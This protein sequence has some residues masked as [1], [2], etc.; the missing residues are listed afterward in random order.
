M[1]LKKFITTTLPYANSKP[2]IGHAFEFVL[3][4]VLTRYFRNTGK[5]VHFNTG[6][7]EHGT[8]IAEAAKNE[9]LTPKQFLDK[10]K[11]SWLTFCQKF[12]ISYD[13]FYRTSSEE[14]HEKVAA[15]WEEFRNRGDFYA[16]QYTGTYC[17]GC[18][19]F[20]TAR[21]LV[22]G[23][24]PDHPADYVS[25]SSETNIFFELTKYSKHLPEHLSKIHKLPEN[26][27]NELSRLVEESAD[28]SVSRPISKC[29]WG[30]PVPKSSLTDGIDDQV[31]Y[32]WFDALLNYIIAS[33]DIGWEDVTIL[34]GPDNLRFQSLIFQSMLIAMDK[35]A[36]KTTLFM[37]GTILD[38]NGHKMSKSK[39]NT[40]DPMDQLKKYGIDAVRY[41]MVA[42]LNPHEDSSWKE[43]DLVNMFNA[44]ICNNFGNL[45]SR[46]I[47]LYETKCEKEHGLADS[48]FLN[49]LLDLN[50]E[51]SL[52]YEEYRV[53]DA[54]NYAREISTKINQYI[55]EKEPWKQEK[56]D[57]QVTIG[58]ALAGLHMLLRLY[59]PVFPDACE[60]L[61]EAIKIHKTKIIAFQ[62]IKLQKTTT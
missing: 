18:E 36:E 50:V 37:H 19:S 46:I 24:C 58:T 14:H 17:K 56:F 38:E 29:E 42:G 28:M 3:A 49:S 6:L 51:A 20:K 26:R 22:D 30:I 10:I 39:G 41:Y 57:C 43:E 59:S 11:T 45:A 12:Q 7:D 62:K 34:F 40:V 53:K 54:M 23:K 31:M 5:D 9:G 4:D 25:D 44:D 60:S 16:K 33:E 48:S 35:R 2:H 15:I 1:P 27:F 61:E 47:H 8:K 13:S 55:T 52:S 21:D 32:V